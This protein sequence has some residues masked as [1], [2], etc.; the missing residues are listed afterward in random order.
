MEFLE[1]LLPIIFMLVVIPS[2]GVLTVVLV[3]LIEKWKEQLKSKIDNELLQK[4]IDLLAN[5]V[6][7]CVVTTNQT[8]VNN[9]KEQGKFDLEAQKIAFQKTYDAIMA[10]LSEEAVNY[11]TVFY[12][13][14]TTTI[15]VLIEQDVNYEKRFS[16]EWI[17][18]VT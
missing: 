3:Q 5:T 2:L 10:I 8:Y 18:E 1:K 6:S 13:D 7:A 4:Y 17:E 9:L 11:L 16:Q 15:T 12:G 14:L